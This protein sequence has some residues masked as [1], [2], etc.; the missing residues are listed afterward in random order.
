MSNTHENIRH[1]I[2]ANNPPSL[3]DTQKEI[4]S[5]IIDDAEATLT[6]VAVETAEQDKTVESLLKGLKSAKKGVTDAHKEDKAPY[7]DGSRRVDAE[8]NELIADLDRA[9]KVAQ[10][11]RTP[12]LNKLEA[13]RQEK[14]RVAREEAEK[15]Q[16]E[17]QEAHQA[18]QGMDVEEEKALAEKEAQAKR[19]AKAAAKASRPAATGLK[20]IW[21]T[22][23][24]NLEQA[25]NTYFDDPRLSSALLDMAK[26][27]VHSGKREIPGFDIKSERI[28]R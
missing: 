15:K 18:K 3:L 7:L 14:A 28:A 16:R 2:G 26:S 5:Q 12:Y 25:L 22:E 8:K 13:E 27:D 24:S 9:I 6:G 23:V 17:L 10:D 11:C 19:A 1:Q 4:V 20:T 21:I